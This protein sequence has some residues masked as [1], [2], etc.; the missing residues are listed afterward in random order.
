M[1]PLFVKVISFTS[2]ILHHGRS[3]TTM[4]CIRKQDNSSSICHCQNYNSSSFI[5]STRPK[6]HSPDPA[7]RD[8]L[9]FVRIKLHTPRF[10]S[11]RPNLAHRDIVV[12]IVFIKLYFYC[13]LLHISADVRSFRFMYIIFDFRKK[14]SPFA[15]LHAACCISETT[16]SKR[17][18]FTPADRKLNTVTTP[19]AVSVVSII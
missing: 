13:R 6:E 10:Q 19:Q 1:L 11:F 12:R 7:D 8:F 4:H 2:N 16:A 15:C 18:Q 3:V 14:R 9:A 17:R 5:S